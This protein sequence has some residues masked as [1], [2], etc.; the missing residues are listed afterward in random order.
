VGDID[1]FEL[2]GIAADHFGEV[3]WG[4]PEFFYPLPKIFEGLW[5]RH[6][7]GKDIMR[8]GNGPMFG[9]ADNEWAGAEGAVVGIDFRRQ[10]GGCSA[11]LT[12][13]NAGHLCESRALL[14]CQKVLVAIRYDGAVVR[15]CYL[16]GGAAIGALQVMGTGCE[17]EGSATAIALQGIILG[18]G[19]FRLLVCSGLV[20]S[21]GLRHGMRNFF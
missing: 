14:R 2:A 18:D 11:I 6:E 5:L 3:G 7:E 16:I 17:L 19:S 12:G 10:C 15:V 9:F 21:F 4:E 13:Y 20:G 1:P 8:F